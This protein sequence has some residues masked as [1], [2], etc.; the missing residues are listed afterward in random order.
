M[1]E[2]RRAHVALA[3]IF[4][5]FGTIDGTWA[6]RLP[7]IK[8]RLGLDSGRLGLAMFSA[9]FVATLTLPFAGMV[10]SRFGSRLPTGVGILVISTGLA[11]AGV[12]PTYV[13][14]VLSAAL[15]GVGIGTLDVAANAHGVSI[16]H[17]VGRPI[18]SSLHGF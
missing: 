1:R 8:D 14:L 6:A 12:A 5:C 7:A 18:L 4:V 3:V 2:L 13:L 17:G 9:T 15:F 16:E 11:C 10:A